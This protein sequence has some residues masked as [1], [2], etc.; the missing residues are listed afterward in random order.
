MKIQKQRQERKIIAGAKPRP[1]VP[2]YISYAELFKGFDPKTHGWEGRGTRRVP[3]CKKCQCNLYPME[4]HVCE[5]Y[6]PQ[7]ETWTEERHQRWLEHCEAKRNGTFFSEDEDD[8]SGYED[9]PEEDWCDEDDGDP[10]WE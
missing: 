9:E 8:L 4:H 7:Y 1:P 2:N 3:K 6:V 10:M 5:G